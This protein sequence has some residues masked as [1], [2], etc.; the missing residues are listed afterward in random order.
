MARQ[1]R[2]ISP[3]GF[4]HVMMR[5]NNREMILAT[6]W[7]KE[8]F[9]ELLSQ[10]S[11]VEI[12][13]YCLMGNHI[14]LVVQAEIAELSDAVKR[15]NIKFA[16]RYNRSGDRV[17]HVFQDR[18]RS[19]VI[20]DESHLLQVIR[21]VHNN[22]VKAGLV[23][24]PE[25]YLW[26]S[27][28]EYVDAFARTANKVAHE[29]VLGQFADIDAFRAFHQ[30]D[31]PEEFLDTQ[32][33]LEQRRTQAVQAIIESFCLAKGVSEAKEIYGN[34]ERLT[35]LMVELLQKTRLSHRRIALLLEVSSS[36]VHR[37]SLRQE[38]RS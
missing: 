29:A 9:K 17:G 27:Y 38:T 34:E 12:A 25:E 35:E 2:K 5:G 28:R 19:E 7:Q 15:M 20:L 10:V 3:T 22:P 14:H 26:S 24:N 8:W 6:K 13:A 4:Y 30:I 37:A 36:L 16:M 18:Y 11:N 32:E 1:A 23:S 21:Y 33:D 31:D